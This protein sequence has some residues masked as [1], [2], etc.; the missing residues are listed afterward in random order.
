MTAYL[1][2]ILISADFLDGIVSPP[3]STSSFIEEASWNAAREVIKLTY[4]GGVVREVPWSSIAPRIPGHPPTPVG[5]YVDH[6]RE[7]VGIHFKGAAASPFLKPRNDDLS[8]FLHGVLKEGGEYQR[9]T[10]KAG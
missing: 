6:D 1:G 5:A 3:D 9:F 4:R 7:C 2:S 8:I 10:S